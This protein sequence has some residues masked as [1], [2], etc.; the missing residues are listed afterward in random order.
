MRSPEDFAEYMSRVQADMFDWPN[1]PEKID[2]YLLSFSDT[3]LGSEGHA[4][5]VS[6]VLD[7]IEDNVTINGELHATAHPACDRC[8]ERY[9]D[10]LLLPIHAHM[11]PLYE[12]ERQREREADEGADVEIIKEDL[13]FSYY[14]GDRIHLD[15][16]IHEQIVLA[17]PMQHVC[18]E[19]C[20]GLCTHCG[21]NLNEGPCGCKQDHSDPRWAA[22]KDFKP[23]KNS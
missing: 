21:A 6:A 1:S 18:S 7:R 2:E 12:S 5:R 15:D 8:L 22:L 10:E 16:F 23:A 3:E 11:I 20:K 19:N 17:L 9:D 14:E 13:E 4:A